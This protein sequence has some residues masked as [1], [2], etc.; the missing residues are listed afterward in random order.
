MALYPS[1]EDEIE[2]KLKELFPDGAERG[3][4]RL[5]LLDEPLEKQRK[6]FRDE[7]TSVRA[8]L[9]KLAGWLSCF[10]QYTL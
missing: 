6:Y 4:V 3:K 7:D 10:W 5:A 9:A 8:L 1:T 2:K